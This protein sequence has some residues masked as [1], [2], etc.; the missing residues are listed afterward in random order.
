MEDNHKLEIYIVN[1]YNVMINQNQNTIH[2]QIGTIPL[3]MF[4]EAE[5]KSVIYHEIGHVIYENSSSYFKRSKFLMK[6]ES[7][8]NTRGIFAFTALFFFGIRQYLEFHFNL[9]QLVISKYIEEQS[10]NVVLN[11]GLNKEFISSAIKMFYFDKFI[12][13][14][15]TMS[16]KA[17][18]EK[19]PRSYFR[20]I[21]NEFE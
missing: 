17:L 3:L 15:D 14:P 11:R 8:S 5:L 1:D 10:D 4:S 21:L 18:K 20:D 16:M 7:M 19:L 13:S 6:L 2:L 12:I 9:H